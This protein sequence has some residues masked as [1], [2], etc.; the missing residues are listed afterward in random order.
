MKIAIVTAVWKRPEVFKF[1]A[2]GVHKLIESFPS[3]QFEVI[4]TGSE[5]TQ[6]EQMV[7]TE[8]FHYIEIPNE[9]LAEKHNSS[10]KKAKQLKPDY[11]LC[12]GSDDI[13][14]PGL[15]EIYLKEISNQPIHFP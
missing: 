12:L 9:P 13:I 7:T 4:V 14:S 5:G 15:F 10:L 2:R 11:V 3:I 1:F 8:G 6:S